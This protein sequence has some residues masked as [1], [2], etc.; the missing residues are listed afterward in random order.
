MSVGLPPAGCL[1]LDLGL[2]ELK[3]PS[4]QILRAD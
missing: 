2:K 4:L 3:V 1:R